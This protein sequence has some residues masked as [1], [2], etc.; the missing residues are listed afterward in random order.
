MKIRITLKDPDGFWE[1]VR[2][3]LGRTASSDNVQ[4]TLSKLKT[5]VEFDEYVTLE[6]D[7]EAKTAIVLTRKAS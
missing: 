7:T 5:W 2:D 3:A 1:G 4:A 6:F